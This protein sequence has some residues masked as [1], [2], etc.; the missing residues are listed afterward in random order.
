MAQE[1]HRIFKNPDSP[2]DELIELHARVFDLLNEAPGVRLSGIRQWL[3]AVREEIGVRLQCWSAEHLE[4][5]V[6]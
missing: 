1:A 4:S 3:L 6:A 5:L 2:I